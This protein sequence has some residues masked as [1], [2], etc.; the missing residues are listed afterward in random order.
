MLILL[1]GYINKKHLMRYNLKIYNE[2][3]IWNLK[4]IESIII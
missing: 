3:K 4:A 1:Y 2:S